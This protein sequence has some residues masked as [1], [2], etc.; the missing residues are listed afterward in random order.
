MLPGLNFYFHELRCV[1]FMATLA[2]LAAQG[3]LPELQMII[4]NKRW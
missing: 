1:Y 3:K 4:F 2:H